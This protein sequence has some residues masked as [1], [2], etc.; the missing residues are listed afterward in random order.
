MDCDVS[1]NVDS[2]KRQ[3]VVGHFCVEINIPAYDLNARI[4]MLPARA[5]VLKASSFLIGLSNSVFRPSDSVYEANA[6]RA[7]AIHDAL[8]IFIAETDRWPKDLA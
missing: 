2:T 5:N 7:E 4:F 1:R 8:G 6:K 3:G